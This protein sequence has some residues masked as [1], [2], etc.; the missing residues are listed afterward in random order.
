MKLVILFSLLLVQI[1]TALSRES[2]RPQLPMYNVF[3]R[4][5]FFNAPACKL[6]GYGIYNSDYYNFRIAFGGYVRNGAD[7]F[8]EAARII[9]TYVENEECR[10]VPSGD[11][12]FHSA[13]I[14]KN[15]FYKHRIGIGSSIVYATNN[16][17]Q[18]LSA[19]KTIHRAGLANRA[20]AM[21]CEVMNG[22]N[23][24][25]GV[26]QKYY[27]S[28]GNAVMYGTNSRQEALSNI[29]ALRDAG[30]CL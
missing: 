2:K 12:Y 19:A 28:I 22:G 30:I 23:M 6:L 17:S 14:Y 13:G 26:H 16:F 25:G 18:A 3:E 11:V 27:V 9:Q 21:Y 8:L 4:H 15:H 1:P 20:T 24:F 5:P 10:S 29:S 7:T